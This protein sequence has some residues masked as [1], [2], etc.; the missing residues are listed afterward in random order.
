MSKKETKNGIVIVA[1]KNSE[2]I[3]CISKVEFKNGKDGLCKSN[4]LITHDPHKALVFRFAHS[5]QVITTYLCASAN[6]Q[7]K[8]VEFYASNYEDI[9]KK[10][11]EEVLKNE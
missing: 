2:I 5:S 7:H 11:E 10:Y 9:V 4:Y 3:G 1:I 6:P 8:D